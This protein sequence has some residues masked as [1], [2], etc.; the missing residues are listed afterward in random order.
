MHISGKIDIK[1]TRKHPESISTAIDIV[2]TH[3]TKSISSKMLKIIHITCTLTHACTNTLAHMHTLMEVMLE[4]TQTACSK[5]HTH[6]YC[7]KRA[8]ELG[9]AMCTSA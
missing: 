5:T 4:C 3:D 1:I 9:H 7:Q 8:S 2:I 6:C